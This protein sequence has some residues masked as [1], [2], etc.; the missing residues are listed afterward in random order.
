MLPF[1][2]LSPAGLRSILRQRSTALRFWAF[3]VQRIYHHPTRLDLPLSRGIL[4]LIHLNTAQHQSML[5]IIPDLQR[6][7]G[8]TI[9]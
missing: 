8:I 5:A 3:L 6:C 4:W 1:N 2:L 7:K 9:F